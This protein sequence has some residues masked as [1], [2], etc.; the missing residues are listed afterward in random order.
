MNIFKQFKNTFFTILFQKKKSENEI[1]NF[2]FGKHS[3]LNSY[4]KLIFLYTVIEIEKQIQKC[5]NKI[6]YGKYFIS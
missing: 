2:F 1:F 6:L 4:F 5:L 3:F